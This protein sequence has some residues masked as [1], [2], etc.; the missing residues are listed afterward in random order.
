[1]CH[2]RRHTC[3]HLPTTYH[4]SLNLPL[5][6][7]NY[8]TCLQPTSVSLPA[9]HWAYAGHVVRKKLAK[10]VLEGAVLSAVVQLMTSELDERTGLL[11][12][13]GVR[14]SGFFLEGLLG[15]CGARLGGC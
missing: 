14:G 1:V 8:H 2:P 4:T 10:A 3:L 13:V 11:K 7:A 9:C 15:G 12:K 6:P 5:F